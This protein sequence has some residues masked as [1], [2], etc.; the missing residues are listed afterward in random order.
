MKKMI[1]AAALAAVAAPALSQAPAP[2][3]D[4]DPAI[5]LVEDE[6]T[7]IYLFGTFHGLDGK[8]DWFNDEVKTAFDASDEVVIEAIL[9][10]DPAAMQPLLLKYAVD[11]SG[12]TLSSKLPAETKAKLEKELATIGAPL[13]AVEAYKP[14][15]VMMT[16][17]AAKAIKMGITPEH[18]A[19]AVLKKA[20]KASG[21]PLGE[22][23]NAEYQFALF[24]KLPEAEQVASLAEGLDKI[25]E[26]GPLMTRMMAAWGEGDTETF[27]TLMKE[28]DAQS[29]AAHKLIFTDRN[30]NWAEWIDARMDKPGTVFFAVGAGHL[31][32]KDSVQDF[33][34]KKGIETEKVED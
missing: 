31:A 11:T 29:P 13:A 17:G 23:E 24:D 19:E 14:F 5:W 7:K 8:R 2:L 6:D 12:R 33:L 32:G 30:A 18:G 28:S 22:V 21:K 1:L 9:P 25:D 15:F 16:L 20:A 34:A 26:F 4:A 3:P 27:V 10:E